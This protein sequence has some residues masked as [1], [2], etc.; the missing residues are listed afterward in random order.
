MKRFLLYNDK[1]QDSPFLRERPY[2]FDPLVFIH[3]EKDVLMR[4]APLLLTAA[5]ITIAMPVMA[6]DVNDSTPTFGTF[7]CKPSFSCANL[8]TSESR[9]LIEGTALSI[10]ENC[11]TQR[12]RLSSDKGFFET[13]MGL[14]SNLYLTTKKIKKNEQGLTMVPKCF[15]RP[16]ENKA[17]TCQV[18]CS[19]YG[20]K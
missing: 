18:V 6:L 8:S 3:Q 7:E 19:R 9:Q 11:V 20:V 10:A 13:A 14:D 12:M 15:V 5:L 1:R 16:V 2:A 4:L 17:N